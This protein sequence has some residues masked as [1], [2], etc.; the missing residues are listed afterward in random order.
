[1]ITSLLEMLR[2]AQHKGYGVPQFNVYNLESIQ[3]VAAAATKLRAPIIL[4]ITQKSLEYGD[5]EP[6]VRL[7]YWYAHHAPVP[8]GVHLDHGRTPSLV[9]RMLEAGFS[10]VH[11]DVSGMR[12]ERGLKVT[13]DLVFEAKARGISVEGE[14]DPIPGR[15]DAIASRSLRPTAVSEAQ[16]FVRL[17]GVDALAVAVGNAHGAR[18]KG[19]KLDL[20]RIKRISS[21]VRIPLVL[22]GASGTPK[23]EVRAAIE[24]GIHK[25]NFD[26]DLRAAA[27]KAL[28]TA[29]NRENPADPR[30]LFAAARAGITTKA[31]ELIRAVRAAGHGT[32]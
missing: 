16:E 22:H 2:A 27:I 23:R 18:V 26:T 5:E 20:E 25:F 31:Q 24:R 6:L 10:S 30:D 21:A 7:A 12:F 1:M 19:E 17:T 11:L 28:A 3:A 14:F 32:G 8:V 15:E 9:K 29:L 4:G 13:A